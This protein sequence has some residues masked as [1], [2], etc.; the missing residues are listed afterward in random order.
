M[1]ETKLPYTHL[2]YV[3]KYSILTNKWE[4]YIVGVNTKDVFHTIGE[5]LY[6]SETQVER[7]NYRECTQKRLDFWQKEGYAIREFKDTYTIQEKEKSKM[8]FTI[9]RANV[10]IEDGKVI[11]DIDSA[12][13]NNILNFGKVQLFTLK[14]KDV[15]KIDDEEFIVLEQTDAGT[16]V[17]SKQFAYSD[18]KF[19][20]CADWRQSPVRAL[21]NGE[22]YDKISRLVGANNIIPMERDLTSLDGLDDYGT[23]IDKITL[24][25]ANEYA[26]YHK[27][28]GL[29]PK[30]PDWWWTI[31]SASTPSNNYARGVCCVHSYGIL[32]WYGC[33]DCGGVRPFLTLDS[34]IFVLE[35]KD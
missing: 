24:L 11:I 3:R 13:I 21:L 29:K 14:P 27:I 17:I 2:L 23:C 31:T 30:Y 5:Y 33:D 1:S 8:K 12:Q 32:G 6:R 22:Y 10:A 16:K 35:N 19:G 28:L 25:S 4:L 9:D 26:K 15:F 18:I 7:I 20:D 34:S